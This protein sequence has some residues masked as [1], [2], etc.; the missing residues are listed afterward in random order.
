M[1]VYIS[2][3]PRYVFV[4]TDDVRMAF[5][6]G[7]H[8]DQDNP[9]LKAAGWTLYCRPSAD[10]LVGEGL[11]REEIAEGV[12]SLAAAIR[13]GPECTHSCP[14]HPKREATG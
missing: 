5:T 9:D 1:K 8:F 3:P 2:D 7:R 4:L 12:A 13:R 6:L 11:Y 14:R 10:K